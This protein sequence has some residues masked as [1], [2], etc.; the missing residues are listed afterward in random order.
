MKAEREIEAL[1]DIEA[2]VFASLHVFP[3]S[4][5]VGKLKQS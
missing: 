4:F 3:A 2:D 5:S 1:D